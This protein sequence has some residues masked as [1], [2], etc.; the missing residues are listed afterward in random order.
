MPIEVQ[1]EKLHGKNLPV[2]KMQSLARA[3][4]M[5]Q[6]N[7]QLADFKRRRRSGPVGQSVPHDAP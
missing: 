1:I 7:L 4:A 5:E 2:E 6:S 3:Y